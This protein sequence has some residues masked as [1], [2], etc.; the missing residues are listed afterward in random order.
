MKVKIGR[1][2]GEHQTIEVKIDSWDTWDM[3]TTLSHIIVPMLKQLKETKH[4][5]P[6]VDP[7]DCP[8][9]LMPTSAE[10]YDVDNT[11]FER[12]DWVLDEMIFAFTSKAMDDWYSQF[13]SGEY[14]MVSKET[15]NYFEMVPG[16]NHTFKI[17]MEGRKA[18]ADRMQRGFEL[19]GKYYQNLWD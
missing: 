18:Y 16:P 10:K 7:K 14:D 2:L 13:E 17:D 4:G 6:Y 8:S 15:G 1:P 3:D 5:A 12:W 19:F 11:H 9:E